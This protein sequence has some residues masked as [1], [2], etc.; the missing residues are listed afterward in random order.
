ME[1]TATIII[2]ICKYSAFALSF[3]YIF[4]AIYAVI[5]IF[6]VKHYDK[7][8]AQNK[9]GIVIAARNESAV[10]GRLLESINRQT[11]PEKRRMTFV[12]AD[13]CTD[14]G[15]TAKLARD[16]GAI[17]YERFD[18]EHCTKG[19]ALEY[20]FDRIKSDYGIDCCDAYVILDADNLLDSRYLEKMNEAFD[21][22]EKIVTSYRMSKNFFSSWIAFSYGV[23]W[24]STV[25]LEHRARSVLSVATRVQGTGYMFASELVRDGWH[26]TCLTE[27]R[28]FAA[29]AVLRGYNIGYCNEAIFYDEQ[30]D[31]LK[32]ALRQRLRWSKGHLRV[33]R[34][35]SPALFRRIFRKPFSKE[36]F[37]AFDMFLITVPESIIYMFIELVKLA[38]LL[39][40]PNPG[41]L[42]V[43]MLTGTVCSYL[44]KSLLAVYVL[45]REYKRIPN[46]KPLK[47][48]PYV[49]MSPLFHTIGKITLVIAMF[50]KVDWRPIPHTKSIGVD[51]LRR[52]E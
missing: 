2:K 27:D 12:V 45:I 9:I 34:A 42:A 40:L 5:G 11:Y 47:I 8:K 19:F 3:F 26:Y 24:M 31:N 29:D 22:G 20:L 35:K 46:P 13:N 30:P 7:A 39:F 16:G 17:C 6:T 21:A 52:S 48:A 38:A 10:I 18:S 14:D 43:A 15:L 33:C 32:I 49:L 44:A 25:L 37:V 51:E 28:E 1:D 4:R 41:E 23:H 50:L 36:S